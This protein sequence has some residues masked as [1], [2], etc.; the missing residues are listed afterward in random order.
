[1]VASSIQSL[2]QVI[3]AGKF[4][5]FRTLRANGN[6]LASV[7]VF[8][9]AQTAQ[10]S[11]VRSDLHQRLPPSIFTKELSEKDLCQQRAQCAV[12]D[13]YYYHD[14]HERPTV[15][16][17]PGLGDYILKYSSR[18]VCGA[19]PQEQNESLCSAR[20]QRKLREYLAEHEVQMCTVAECKC[21]LSSICQFA[22]TVVQYL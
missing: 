8:Q 6:I 21:S 20:M 7:Y 4:V 14:V 5:L 11:D 16:Y 17:G 18:G 22:G 1:M 15:E 19:K 3:E 13:L 10:C 2:H 9:F 12:A